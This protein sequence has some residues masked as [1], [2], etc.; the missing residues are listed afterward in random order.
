[1]RCLLM[2]RIRFPSSLP[3]ERN[4]LHKK[5]PSPGSNKSAQEVNSQSGGGQQSAQSPDEN[6]SSHRPTHRARRSQ[7]PASRACGSPQSADCASDDSVGFPTTQSDLSIAGGSPQSDEN[8]DEYMARVGRSHPKIR[9]KTAASSSG[10]GSCSSLARVNAEI[11]DDDFVQRFRRSWREADEVKKKTLMEDDL[12]TLISD[13]FKICVLQSF[14]EDGPFIRRLLGEMCGMEWQRKQMDL[15]EFHQTTDFANLTTEPKPALKAFYDILRN[16][17]LPWMRDVSGLDLSYVSASC[18]MYNYGDFL[19]VHDD[20]LTD[21]QIAFVYYVSP[22]PEAERWTEEMGGALELF[23]CDST[24]GQPKYPIVKRIPP[25]NNQFTFFRVCDKSFHQVGEVTNLVYPRL[26]IN[27][28]FHG[29]P[30]EPKSE[31]DDSIA[32]NTSNSESNSAASA[33][34]AANNTLPQTYLQYHSP[35]S[36]ELDLSEWINS[37]YLEDDLKIC[38]QRHIEQ[39]SEASLE[40]FLIPDFY[41]LLVSEFRDNSDLE[42]QLE[43]PADQRKYETLRLT[44]HSTGPPKDLHTLFSSQAMFNLLQQYTEL[45]L[46]GSSAMRPQC[47]VQICRFT[48]G[49]YTLLGDSSTFSE[50]ALDIVLFFN[51]KNAVGTVTYL[52]PQL[53]EDDAGNSTDADVSN[54]IDTSESAMAKPS[55]SSKTPSSAAPKKEANSGKEKKTRSSK[56]KAVSGDDTDSSLS[57]E[58]QNDVLLARLKQ[59]VKRRRHDSSSDDED[60][61]NEPDNEPEENEES[62]FDMESDVEAVDILQREQVLLTI[63]PKNNALNLVYRSAGQTKFVKYVSKNCIEADEFV[64]ILFATYKE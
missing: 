21:R 23:E 7:P 58:C 57:L 8:S 38:I 18:S 56:S 41:D 10:G 29:R 50:N 32:S 9:R 6:C 26:T 20:L 34:E 16:V 61:D 49:C 60:G 54:A 31:A 11:T 63:H 52:S 40:L 64:Y 39:T 15:Y 24:T 35:I 13:P 14:I 36:E 3:D 59:A 47:S 37:S 28:W 17:M 46:D 53:T 42:W 2:K 27:G 25:R 12:V 43:G 4:S 22:W 19:L 55:G 45:D 62:D 30:A 1:M 5:R 44:S 51:T 48:Q 33:L